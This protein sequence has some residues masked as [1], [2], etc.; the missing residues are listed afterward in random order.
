VVPLLRYQP[1][2]SRFGPRL[3]EEQKAAMRAEYEKLGLAPEDLRALEI[4]SQ[5]DRIDYGLVA[6][7]V[8]HITNT[9]D[10]GAILIFMPG[11]MEIRQCVAEL[12]GSPLGYV[13]ILP[14]HAN[15]SSAEQRR[16]FVPTKG[17]KIVVAT[18]VAET[19][20]TI[21]DVVYVIDSGRVKETQYDAE[22]GMQRL[23]ECWTSRAS[24]RQRRGRAG[25]TQ[26]GQCYKMYSHRTENNSMPRFPV[27]EIMRT[28]LEALFLQVKAMNEETDVKAFLSRA[29]DP[30]KMASMDNAWQTLLD[31]GAVE[32]DKQTAKL[33]AL[34]RHMSLLPVDL[35]LAKMMVLGTIF[36]CLDP[37]LT[38]AALLSSKPLFATPM[39]R[40]DE[41]RKARE[42]FSTARSDLLTDAKAY[43][44]A[45]SL[46]RGEARSFCDQNFISPSTL[47]DVTSLRGDFIAALAGIGFIGSSAASLAAASVNAN[48]DNLV[49]AVIVG[50]LY[51]R[52]ARIALPAAQF[53]RLHAGAIQKEHEAREVKFF[54]SAGRVFLHP[55]SVLFSESGW[56]KGYLAYFSKAETSKVFLRDATEVPMYGLLLFGGQITVNHWAGGLMLG[57]DGVVKLRA[58]TRIGVLCA[59]LRRLLDAQLA[60]KIESPHG[61][62]DIR[63]DVTQAMM[64]L[65][66]RDGL[67][68]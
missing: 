40:R 26:P 64:A 15:L 41:A 7:M 67:T 68:Q 58:A 36:K 12:Q 55:S 43:A 2:P 30:P 25:R 21:P 51:P 6:A 49:K 28:P 34:G 17:R 23:V 3:N 54:D 45:A 52:V 42:S 66:A 39:D 11:V 32:S 29:I 60:E 65:L 19:S 48:N 5:S 22:N 37:V 8:K 4:L 56:R 24:G 35:R 13:D 1:N 10:S 14:L 16:V 57:K 63:D 47:R 53:E 38:V 20:V 27:P 44:A 9:S 18:N 61:A 46:R 62:A 59:Q 31:L 50:G 33:T